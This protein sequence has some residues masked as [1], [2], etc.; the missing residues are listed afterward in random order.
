V[1]PEV[2]TYEK[3]EVGVCSLVC[4]ILGIERRVGTLGWGLGQVTSKSIIHNNLP[5]PNNKLVSAWLEHFWLYR[6][7]MNIYELTKLTMA[8]TWGSHQVPLYSIFLA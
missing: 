8:W 2:E 5:K 4:N 6:Q 1:N 7:T 3:G